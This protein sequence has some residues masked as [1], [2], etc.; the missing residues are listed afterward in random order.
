MWDIIL[1]HIDAGRNIWSMYHLIVVYKV[2]TGDAS[3][4]KSLKV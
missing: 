3:G 4:V 1:L 2:S